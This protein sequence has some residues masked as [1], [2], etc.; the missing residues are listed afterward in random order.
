MRRLSSCEDSKT[1]YLDTHL[2]TKNLI[3]SNALYVPLIGEEIGRRQ[4]KEQIALGSRSKSIHENT[5][6]RC[7]KLVS[8]D[9]FRGK[10]FKKRLYS[11][12]LG[13]S[14]LRYIGAQHVVFV[15]KKIKLRLRLLLYEE[16]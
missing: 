14:Y 7:N 10:R 1:I 11:V 9:I 12:F 6:V 3:R 4:V 8:L 5:L 13:H 2:R 15:L 16:Q